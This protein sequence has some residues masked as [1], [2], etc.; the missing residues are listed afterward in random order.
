MLDSSLRRLLEEV[1]NTST[2]LAIVLL[3]AEHERL[4]ATPSQILQRVCRDIWSVEKALRELAADG[5]LVAHDGQ[6]RYRPAPQWR[7][8][9]TR[10]L[11]AYDEPLRRDEIM[12]VVG[13]LDRYAPYR[14]A[15]GTPATIVFST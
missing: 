8:A 14:E 4:S 11:A 6:Y 13:E 7:E 12:R 5:I 15:L 3:Y 1:V 9:L 2:K 10:L